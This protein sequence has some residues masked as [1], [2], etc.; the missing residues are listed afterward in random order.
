MPFKIWSWALLVNW[1]LIIVTYSLNLFNNFIQ[2]VTGSAWWVNLIYCLLI[3]PLTQTS[4]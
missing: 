4:S 3:K 1:I 2:I